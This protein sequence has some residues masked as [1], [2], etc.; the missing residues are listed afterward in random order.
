MID[1]SLAIRTVPGRPLCMRARIF[2]R[3]DSAVAPFDTFCLEREVQERTEW[4]SERRPQAAHMP[5]QDVAKQRGCHR[6]G[7]AETWCNEGHVHQ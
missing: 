5:N 3:P 7:E 1:A 4:K 6:Q 2:L